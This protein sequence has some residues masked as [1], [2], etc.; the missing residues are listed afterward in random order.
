MATSLNLQNFSDNNSVSP[1]LFLPRDRLSQIKKEALRTGFEQ[2]YRQAREEFDAQTSDTASRL[3]E[4]LQDIEFTHMEARNSILD[5]LE[6]LIRKLVSHLLPGL[7]SDV[8]SDVIAAQVI[9]VASLMTDAP[10]RICC[11]PENVRPLE[12][13][14]AR[15]S[16]LSVSVLVEANPNLNSLEVT[17]RTSESERHLDIGRILEGIQD[18]VSE[19]YKMA[20][21]GKV[22]G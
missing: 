1:T 3:S 16:D 10:I 7:A 13:T 12:D 17:L 14:I 8:L 18:G 22:N 20:M 2:G 19:F 6:P 5:S 9:S 21:K 15:M 11:A 4:N